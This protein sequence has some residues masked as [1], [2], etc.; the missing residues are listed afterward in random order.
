MQNFSAIQ[1][2]TSVIRAAERG[3]YCHGNGAGFVFVD[4]LRNVLY[5][6]NVVE[7][8]TL[9]LPLTHLAAIDYLANTPAHRDLDVADRLRAHVLRTYNVEV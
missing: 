5:S 1:H 8:R 6:V 9:E 7:Q 3:D 2:F 4:R